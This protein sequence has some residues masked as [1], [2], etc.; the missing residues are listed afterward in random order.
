MSFP[1]LYSVI[2]NYGNLD[3][4]RTGETSYAIGHPNEL[5]WSFT[6]GMVSSVRPD[7]NWQYKGSKHRA[8]VIQTEA[9]INPGNSGGPLFNKRKELIGVNTFTT[10]GENLNFAIAVNDVVD[11]ISEKPKPIKKKK[12]KYIQKKDKGNTWITKKKKKSSSNETID[13]LMARAVNRQP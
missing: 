13:L 6:S 9:S 7:Y 12:S 3:N 2:F 8:N 10:D 4:V 1:T 5:L 11:F